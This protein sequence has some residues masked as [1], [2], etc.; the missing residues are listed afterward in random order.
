[1]CTNVLHELFPINP[2]LCTFSRAKLLLYNYYYVCVSERVFRREDLN[3]YVYKYQQ[4]VTRQ[5]AMDG[6]DDWKVARGDK[7]YKNGYTVPD[8]MW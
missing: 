4:L 1:M 8:S 5:S 2:L 6:S 7:I 3:S